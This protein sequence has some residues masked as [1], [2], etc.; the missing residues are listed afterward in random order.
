MLDMAD[1]ADEHQTVRCPGCA[2][3][4]PTEAGAVIPHPTSRTNPADCWGSGA[5]R[6]TAAERAV[7]RQLWAQALA[8]GDWNQIREAVRVLALRQRTPS[9]PD[10]PSDQPIR[11]PADTSALTSEGDTLLPLFEPPPP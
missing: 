11:P 10:T 1:D 8:T 3:P 2:L 5:R 4:R 6:R 9:L 7:D